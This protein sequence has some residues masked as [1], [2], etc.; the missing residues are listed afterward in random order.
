MIVYNILWLIVA[1]GKRATLLN[2]SIVNLQWFSRFSEV[3]TD[4]LLRF[5]ASL[6]RCHSGRKQGKLSRSHRQRRKR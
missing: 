1:F 3:S 4:V 2:R 6:R 5:G